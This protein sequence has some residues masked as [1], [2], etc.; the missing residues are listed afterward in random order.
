MRFS[1]NMENVEKILNDRTVDVYDSTHAVAEAVKHS[2]ARKVRFF[3][4]QGTETIEG[5]TVT[6]LHTPSAA[7]MTNADV[8]ILDGR[9]LK[10]LAVRYPSDA[11]C[12]LARFAFRNGWILGIPGILRRVLLGRVRIQGLRYLQDAAGK[13]SY[14]IVISRTKKTNPNKRLFV[15]KE[16]GVQELIDWLNKERISYVVLRFYEHLPK[17]HREDGDLDLLVSDEDTPRVE[18]YL[19]A[20]IKNFSGSNADTTPIGLHTVSRGSGVPYYP[21]PLARQ[22]LTQSV[23]G[24]AGAR[25]PS[26][27]DALHSFVYHALYHHKGYATGIPTNLE[28]KPEH[29]PENDYGAIIER[30]AR[31]VGVEVGNTMEEMDEYMESVGWRPKRDTLAKIAERNSWVRDRFFSDKGS[32][33]SG[34]TVYV[35]KERAIQEKKM[36]VILETLKRNGIKIVRVITFTDIERKRATEH[37]RGGNWVDAN[38]SSEGL[39][40]IA[41]II[42]VDPRCVNLPPAYASEYERACAKQQ[43]KLLREAIDEVDKASLVHAADNTQEAWEYVQACFPERIQ[44]LEQEIS[45]AAK[46]S[47]LTRIRRFLS[48]AYITHALRFRLRDFV[49]RQLT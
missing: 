43:K 29:P 46:T 44:E 37:I 47:A 38:N 20:C 10:V 18:E 16:V 31:N 8:C 3:S 6:K 39:L 1:R 36:D 15:A 41:M 45:E 35:V 28:G 19:H 40:P 21:P 11:H 22:I 7:G 32:G 4:S 30:L 25:I 23:E 33:A 34:L 17:I 26:P 2:G 14:W 12:I 9:A 49:V 24:P 42:G 27:E 48:I 5:V 13:K